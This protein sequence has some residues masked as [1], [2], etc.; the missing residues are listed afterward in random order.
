M[1]QNTICYLSTKFDFFPKL[2]KFSKFLSFLKINLVYFS[3]LR[4]NFTILEMLFQIAR[5]IWEAFSK[6]FSK[7]THRDYKIVCWV[8]KIQIDLT[9]IFS[10]QVSKI[11]CR[12]SNQTARFAKQ[13]VR[14][15]KKSTKK[16]SL[17]FGDLANYFIDPAIHFGDQA[18]YFGPSNLFCRPNDL[19][20][21][22]GKLFWRPSDLF[23]HP[24]N[25]FE[26]PA[27]Y[28]RTVGILVATKLVSFILVA[29]KLVMSNW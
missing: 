13:L 3:E 29:D 18:I 27:I 22:P 12:V 17:L 20:R 7:I 1:N 25:Y 24:A 6:S 21:R 23:R 16:S 26:D 19:F 8:C 5:L 15:L 2:R 4:R 11:I 10:P 14:S 28:F 9:Q